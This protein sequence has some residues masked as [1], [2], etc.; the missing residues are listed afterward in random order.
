MWEGQLLDPSY[1]FPM[2]QT[3]N[4][5]D[6]S[7]G[8]D[9]LKTG[10]FK[11]WPSKSLDFEIRFLDPHCILELEVALFFQWRL[12]GKSLK[13][14]FIFVNST[15]VVMSDWKNKLQ[16]IFC[17]STQFRIPF[18]LIFF[19]FHLIFTFCGHDIDCPFNPTVVRNIINC[20]PSIGVSFKLGFQITKS[21]NNQYQ[22]RIAR[23]FWNGSNAISL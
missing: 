5:P 3:S 14:N 23:T 17:K 4:G 2:V 13:C 10:P 7:Y 16:Y 1:Q 12:L 6:Y 9:H 15:N 22:E 8:P 19:P 21:L 11:F 20:A 18:H